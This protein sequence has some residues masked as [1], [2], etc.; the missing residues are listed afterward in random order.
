MFLLLR[1]IIA[2][3]CSLLR[4]RL[5]VYL[6]V[7]IAAVS[8]V[9]SAATALFFS[10]MTEPMTAQA[11]KSALQGRVVL[12]Q[13]EWHERIRSKDYWS[14]RRSGP[15]PAPR[16]EPRSPMPPPHAWA[17]LRY[18]DDSPLGRHHS[19]D[20]ET[21][22]TMCVRLCDGYFW[23][24]SFATTTDNFARDQVT[25]DRSCGAPARLFVYKNP[26][27]EPTEMRSV[28]G[29]PYSRLPAAFLFRTKYE[30][31]CRCTAQPWEKE[32]Q[33]RHRIY[34]LEAAGRKGDR[35]AA[36]QAGELRATIEIDRRKQVQR[37]A[38]AVSGLKSGMITAR[39]NLLGQGPA[40]VTAP[41]TVQ[42]IRP[43][44]SAPRRLPVGPSL[45]AAAGPI[46]TVKP[47][48]PASAQRQQ[49]NPVRA[50]A[51]L[52]V[53]EGVVIMRLGIGSEAKN[54]SQ[55]DNTDLRNRSQQ[56]PGRGF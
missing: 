44:T 17:A 16:V 13:D 12:T 9:A 41:V 51:A 26:G 56:R 25:C 34:A 55:P 5:G 49:Q 14:G 54:R 46:A 48:P 45:P 8:L 7:L 23:P 4:G 43:P 10:I 21:Y 52:P 18:R 15:A 6:G 28:D 24:V 40:P 53:P 35:T 32:A 36:K 1:D 19:G 22:R 20:E 42:V 33:D 3:C 38:M 50:I 31:M 27:E 29:Q 39:A 30:P 2:G 47:L 37:T 11:P